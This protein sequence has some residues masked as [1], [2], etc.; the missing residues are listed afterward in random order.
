MSD[1]PRT[2]ALCAEFGAP[3]NSGGQWPDFARQLER[4][5]AAERKRAEAFKEAM[6]S[7]EQAARVERDTSHRAELGASDAKDAARYRWLRDPSFNS[8]C[9]M[10]EGFYGEALDAAID[11]AIERELPHSGEG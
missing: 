7:Y 1:T 4:E 3:K 2:D 9:V 5:L 10:D 8:S 6:H 11:A